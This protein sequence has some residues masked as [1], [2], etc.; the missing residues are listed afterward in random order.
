M[1][2]LTDDGAGALFPHA[3]N[4]RVRAVPKSELRKEARQRTSDRVE[5][6]T[7]LAI[8]Y[9]RLKALKM[10]LL[11]FDREIVSWGHGLVYRA[12]LETAKSMLHFNCPS[13]LCDG[14]GFDLS[15]DLSTAV[16]GREKII[17]GVVPCRGS[18]EQETGKMTPCK[19]VLHFKMKLS[20]ETRAPARHNAMVRKSPATNQRN[21]K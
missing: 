21:K 4:Y 15:K 17:I 5:K 7:S 12:N 19:S 6:S 8:Q 11:Y 14:G 3:T 10:N 9:P 18:R 13:S 1:K 2:T 20:F 16:A